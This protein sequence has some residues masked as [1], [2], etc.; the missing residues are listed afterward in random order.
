[1]KVEFPQPQT[2]SFHSFHSFAIHCSASIGSVKEECH[3]RSSCP[4]FCRL[5]GEYLQQNLLSTEIAGRPLA[6]S[7]TVQAYTRSFEGFLNIIRHAVNLFLQC[8]LTCAAI[9]P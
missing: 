7:H 9:V 6:E 1:M 3:R 4:S 8:G 2:F 5:A